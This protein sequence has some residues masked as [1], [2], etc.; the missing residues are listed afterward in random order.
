MT[1]SAYNMVL[2]GDVLNIGFGESP[3]D[4]EVVLAAQELINDLRGE[5]QGKHLKLNG[6]ASLS[7]AVMIGHAFGN[8]N[9]TIAVFLPK[10][11]QYIVVVSFVKSIPVGTLID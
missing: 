4:I 1:S 10:L 11:Q 6:P 7:V 5:A 8:T 9:Q 2:D 3:T